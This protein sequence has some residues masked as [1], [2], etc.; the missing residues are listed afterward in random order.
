MKI[1]LAT[2]GS[3]CSEG[4]ARF[5]T[6]LGL[7]AADEVTVFHAV[8]WVPFLYD[9]QSYVE[10]LTEIRREIA[11]KILDATLAILETTGAKL[12]TAIVDGAADYYIVDAAVKS[13]MDMIVMGARGVKGIES[14]FVGSV[15]KSV[16]MTSPLPVLVTKMPVCGRQ[17][18]MKI[19]L[20]TDGSEYSVSAGKMLT[21]VPFPADAELTLLNVVWSDFSDIPERFVLEVNERIKEVVAETRSAELREAERIAEQARAELSGRFGE[22]AVMTRIGDPSAEILKAAEAVGADL[23]TV[24]CRGLRGIKGMMGS[25]SRN[26]LAHSKCAVLI[27]RQC[28]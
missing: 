27:G 5:L 9:R 4:A 13:G 23:I 3:A 2:D 25:V 12:S 15:T 24:G 18:R 14:I 19:L 16:S 10:T 21:R 11:P 28:G 1:L 8:S 6:C 22:V 26:I 20:A 17:K 7:G